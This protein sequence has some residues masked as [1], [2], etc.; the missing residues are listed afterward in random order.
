MKKTVRCLMMLLIMLLACSCTTSTNVKTETYDLSE[1]VFYNTSDRFLSSDDAKI[2]FGKDHSFVM[3]DSSADG[4]DEITGTWEINE[5]VC[6]L[7]AESSLLGYSGK[8]LFEIKDDNTLTLKTSVHDSRS[9]DVYSTTKPER[10][11]VDTKDDTSK[12]Y[13][14]VNNNDCKLTLNDDRTFV[15]TEN[16]GGNE[17][18]INGRYGLE[19]NVY[20]FSNFLEFA[21]WKGET[22]Y[23]FEFFVFDDETL[24][25]MCDL[26]ASAQDDVFTTDGK[27]PEDFD[28]KQI[29]EKNFMDLW[30]HEP[31]EYV[32]EEYLPSVKFYTDGTF[33]FTENLYAGMGDLKGTYEANDYGFICHV[34]DASQ[35]QG[36]KGGDVK[37]I[38]FEFTAPG[39]MM[40]KTELCMSMA[41]DLF[42]QAH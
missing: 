3:T 42:Y 33:V 2:W 4:G 41:G 40:L 35:I 5:N 24:I 11:P 6:T 39:T 22:T 26:F 10:K 38:E 31:D 14:N 30:V 1:K 7:N 16:N 28:Q 34:D 20:M 18:T 37:T 15:L 12:T 36:F 8:I 32:L 21:N 25:S 9:D 13:Y 17:L 23:N 29:D 27:M 19:G